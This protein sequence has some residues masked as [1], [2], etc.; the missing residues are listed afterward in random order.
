MLFRKVSCVFAQHWE[1]C[2]GPRCRSRS[3]H[4]PECRVLICVR[5]VHIQFGI[6]VLVLAVWAQFFI[7]RKFLFLYRRHDSC[8]FIEWVYVF[9]FC[10]HV[11]DAF[12]KW[13]WVIRH[14]DPYVFGGPVPVVDRHGFSEHA[15]VAGVLDVV[16]VG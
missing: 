2:F 4:W 8:S 13:F 16:A 3:G 9:R 14:V 15:Q 1:V 10:L 7:K 5:R 6:V 11:L 12:S